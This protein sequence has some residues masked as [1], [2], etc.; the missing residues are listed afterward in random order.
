MPLD[1]AVEADRFL[2]DCNAF[3][4]AFGDIVVVALGGVVVGVVGSSTCDSGERT[5]FVSS[6]AIL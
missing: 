6:E 3:S 4:A 5:E 1:S 2:G